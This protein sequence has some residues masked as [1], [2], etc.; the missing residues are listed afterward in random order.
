MD[1]VGSRI[2]AA[3]KAAGMTQADLGEKMG[4]KYQNITGWETGKRNPTIKSICRLAT[5][6]NV[7]PCWLAFGNCWKEEL[8][9]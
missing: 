4:I 8:Y 6:L 5:L 3:R 1:T 7:K 2:K 9:G